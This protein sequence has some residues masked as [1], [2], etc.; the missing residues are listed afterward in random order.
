MNRKYFISEHSFK[1]QVVHGTIGN[2]DAEAVLPQLG[3]QPIQFP[4]IF[5]F[6]FKT[7]LARLGYLLKI[8]MTIPAGAIVVFQ[9]PLYARMHMLLTRLLRWKKIH[10]VCLIADIEGQRNLDAALLQKEIKTLRLF[11]WFIVHNDR[12]AQWIRDTI[13]HAQTAALEF[14]DFLVPPFTAARSRSSQVVFAGNLEKSPFIYEAEKI[15]ANLQ[16]NI[17]GPGAHKP[18]PATANIHYKGVF[19]ARSLIHHL[20]G[21]FGL[22]WDG[23]SIEMLSGEYGEYLAYNSPHKLSLYILAGLPI[24]APAS[25]ASAYLVKKY[26]IGI[27]VNSLHEIE[28]AI[29]SITEENY[30]QMITNMKPLAQKI[31]SGECLADALAVVNEKVRG[32]NIK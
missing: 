18:L 28:N 17:Y 3:Y 6:S 2:V 32:S 14:F 19:E 26:G 1:E 4:G 12:M 23:N 7:K 11:K 5:S 27:T 24:I 8:L 16:F 13:P 21:S 9:F 31:S 20:Q 29:N 25:S 30:Q 10:I 22:I 15:N